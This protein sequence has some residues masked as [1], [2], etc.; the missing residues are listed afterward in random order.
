MALNTVRVQ[1]NGTW[2]NLTKNAATGKY[3]GTIAAPAITSYNINSGHY[4]PVIV[5]ATDLAGN[6]TTRN[7]T[8][9][10]LGNSLKLYVKETTKP[11]VTLT[12]PASGAYLATNTPV[13]SF[14]LR[15]ETNGSGIKISSLVINLD[16][17][18]AITNTSAGVT[19]TSVSGGYNIT[20]TPQ[21]ALSD[22]AHTV[23]VDIQDNDG[24]SAV[25]ATRSF[26]VD[27]IPPTLNITT[28]AESTTYRNNASITLV[29]STNDAISSPV[30]ITVK[31]NSGNADTVVVDA[32][33]NFNKALSLVEGTNTITVTA[34]DLA[35]KVSIVT[36]TIILDTVAPVIS[37]IA[38]APNPVNVGQSY[39]I[40]V[41]VSD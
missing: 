2:V 23:T 37:S 20:Y 34:T 26:K 12:A 22:G 14:Q 18:T 30:T 31:L 27:T 1:M 33:G 17:G 28:P 25:Q 10:N 40:T 29:G 9:S 4:Y 24:N 5:E 39:V 15:D 3:E 8:D 35:G 19:V 36:R 7:D 38:I 16:S 41:E 21:K 13:I 32:S 11:T 6:I